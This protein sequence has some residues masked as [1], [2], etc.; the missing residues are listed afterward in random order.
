MANELKSIALAHMYSV[1]T[2]GSG[3]AALKGGNFMGTAKDDEHSKAVISK[4]TVTGS[5]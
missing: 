4:R 2:T 1:K 3:F 5:E